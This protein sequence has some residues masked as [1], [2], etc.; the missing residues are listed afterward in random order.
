M[1][2][3]RLTTWSFLVAVAVIGAACG[4]GATDQSPAAA[5]E[6]ATDAAT[7]SDLS[8][9][10]ADESPDESNQEAPDEEGPIFGDLVEG[11]FTFTGAID[12]RYGVSGDEYAFE[13]SGGCA[14]DVFGFS[15]I[16]SDA[17]DETPLA[18]LEV[19]MNEDLSGGV[20]G[21]FEPDTSVYIF[22]VDDPNSIESFSAPLKMTVSEHDT[23]G[24]NYDLDRRRMT[25]A[26][27]GTVSGNSD[28]VDVDVTFRWIMG[29]P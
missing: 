3:T 25:I 8:G 20:T 19:G 29:C 16:I 12:E 28:S 9:D 18:S 1:P 15:V 27:L 6:N 21:E 14:G 4:G 22:P 17:A 10:A 7:A 11:S 24:T 26:I 13:V 5:V 23:G 2:Q